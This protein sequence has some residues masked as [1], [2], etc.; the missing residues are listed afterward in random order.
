MDINNLKQSNQI[1][2]EFVSGSHL[3]GLNIEGSDIDVRGIF[4][5]KDDELFTV[6]PQ[7]H[8]VSDD[9]NDTCYYSLKKFLTLAMKGS[10]NVIEFLFCD[11]PFIKISSA[12]YEHLR[13]N[14]DIFV[15]KE[16]FNTYFG[17]ANGQIHRATGKNKKANEIP[18]RINEDGLKTIANLYNCGKCS[19]ETLSQIFS[20]AFFQYL[21]KI[22]L[23]KNIPNIIYE[24][25]YS[26]A[27]E[28]L[29]SDENT[30]KMMPPTPKKYLRN[31]YQYFPDMKFRQI[32]ETN[33]ENGNPLFYAKCCKDE[34]VHNLY[35]MYPSSELLKFQNNQFEVSSILIDEEPFCTGLVYFN[36]DAYSHEL[37][38]WK[39]F[40]EWMYDRSETRYEHSWDEN[41]QYDAKNMM[42]TFR[43]LYDA[44]AIFTTGCPKVKFSGETKAYLLDIRFGKHQYE[45]LLEH[46][47]QLENEIRTAFSQ[48]NLPSA[49]DIKSVNQLYKEL[50]EIGNM[51]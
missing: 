11:N 4:F 51:K 50:I 43:L 25:T 6:N 5:N 42:H 8:Q 34:F 9:T 45:D 3:Y 19:K 16:L 37:N 22:G 26:R 10:P 18:E 24:W 28:F 33:F 13:A 44:L 23:I 49:V 31:M 2:F 32:P 30:T 21:D 48:S 38:Q 27:Y 41:K 7:F 14:R 35:R 36:E 17:Y 39:S 47:E 1:I 40:W 12:M 15:T 20:T 29:E 46:V